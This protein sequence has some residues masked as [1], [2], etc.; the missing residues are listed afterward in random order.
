MSK[1]W[2]KPITSFSGRNEEMR[3]GREGAGGGGHSRNFSFAGFLH[4]GTGPLISL[5]NL[6][7]PRTVLSVYLILRPCPRSS[8]QPHLTKTPAAPLDLGAVAESYP[9]ALRRGGRGER[10]VTYSGYF[11]AVV[12]LCAA[13]VVSPLHCLWGS[14]RSTADRWYS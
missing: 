7:L 5:M 14:A 4:F 3:G 9:P 2:P 6:V 10:F 13:V 12:R 8:P 11:A 1:C